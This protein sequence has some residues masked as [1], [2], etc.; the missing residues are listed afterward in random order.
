MRKRFEQQLVIGQVSIEDTRINIKSKHALDELLA[1]LKAIYCNKEYNEKIFRILEKHLTA[2]KKKTGREGMNLW[3]VFVLS[4]VR[5]CLNTSYDMLHNLANNHRTMRQLMG[6]EFDFGYDVI[7]FEYQ[8]IYDNVTMLSD[9]L[10]TEINAVILEFGH[11]EVFKKKEVTALRLKTDS[12][13]VES[14]VHFP[15]DYNLLWDCARKNLDTVSKFQA[16]YPIRGWRKITNNI[17]IW[18]YTTQFTNFLAP[19]PDIHTL[20][21]NIKFLRDNHAKWVFEQHSNNPSELFELRSYIMAKLLW[22]PDL[23]V[24]GLITEFTNGYYQEA[25]VFV[26]KYVNL[27]HMKIQEDSDFFLFLYGDPSQAFDSYLNPELLQTYNDY[28][29]DAEEAVAQKPEILK[30]VKA[31]RLSTD[32][33]ILE[34]CKKNLSE[35]FSMVL[36][37]ESGHK[38]INKSVV[39]RLEKFYDTSNTAN[40]TL[41]NEMGFTVSEYYENYKKAI[42][43]AEKPNK[44]K[45]KK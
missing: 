21:P 12:F 3:S 9:E 2:G 33:A 29:D 14:N 6:V 7:E 13:V 45:G 35:V 25:G 32:Y 26:K 39:D 31:A 16:K 17:R 28:F 10:I 37:D 27:I 11:G 30:R 22:N 24:E 1:A 18:D 40:I 19:F 15:T 4:Q 41:M 20:Q 42:E 23:D 5:L 43:V 8:N 44:A 34:A 38:I 36:I